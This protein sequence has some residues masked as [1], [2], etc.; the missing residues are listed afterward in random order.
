MVKSERSVSINYYFYHSYNTFF[1]AQKSPTLVSTRDLPRRALFQSPLKKVSEQPSKCL[2]SLAPM[3]DISMRVE[4]SKRALHFSPQ[5]RRNTVVQHNKRKRESTEDVEIS[6][7]NPTS[8]VLRFKRQSFCTGTDTHHTASNRNLS[9]LKSSEESRHAT[10]IRNEEQTN[11]MDDIMQK[12]RS[13]PTAKVYNLTECQRKKI[14]WAISY[15]LREKQINSEHEKFKDYASI[16]AR[17]VKRLFEEYYH[18]NCVSTSE[19]LLK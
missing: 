13:E 16:L 3:S 5:N 9:E 4:K 14:L 8:C 7:N 18:Q 11:K 2:Q 1:I 6:N 15:A 19:T 17:V 10:T 12:S